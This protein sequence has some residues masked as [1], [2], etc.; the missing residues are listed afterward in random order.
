ME[1]LLSELAK[2]GSNKKLLIPMIVSH[3]R[4]KKIPSDQVVLFF[5]RLQGWSAAT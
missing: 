5:M 1:K 3:L 4:G 2:D